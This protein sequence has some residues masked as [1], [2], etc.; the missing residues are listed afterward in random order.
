MLENCD[1]IVIFPIYSHFGAMQKPDSKRMVC[2]SYILIIV[3]FC[4]TKTKSRTKKFVTQFSCYCFESRYYFCNKNAD[5]SKIKGFLEL[6]GI[7]SETTYGCVLAYRILS[8]SIILMSN[9][10]RIILL[11]PPPPQSEPL[12][13]PPRL[14]L[15][16]RFSIQQAKVQIIQGIFMLIESSTL[17]I[18]KGHYSKV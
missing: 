11:P 13:S 15:S 14:G 5:I 12:R 1:V 2:K 7:F 3:T 9:K 18:L 17:G 4:L 16:K 8:F 10:L 6:K